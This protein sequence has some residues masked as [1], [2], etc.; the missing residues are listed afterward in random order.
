MTRPS[1]DAYFLAMAHN[2]ATRATCPRKHVG[3]VIV[4]G[5]RVVAT[6]FNGS[7]SG[8][9]HCEEIG[10]LET[11]IGGK[12][13]CIRTIHAELNALLQAGNAAYGGTIYSTV[14][15]CFECAKALIQAG[16]QRVVYADDYKSRNADLT[17]GLFRDAG[18]EVVHT[19]VG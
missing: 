16:I 10:C 14:L 12:L 7:P 8:L 11:E 18:V 19:P 6:G 1:W 13:S 9:D 5:R 15:P 4:D 2:A 17:G 3:A